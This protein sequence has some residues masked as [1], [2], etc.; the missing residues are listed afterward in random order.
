MY[1]AK[2]KNQIRKG[3]I[4]SSISNCKAFWT[5]QNYGDSR[6]QCLPGYYQEQ[7]GSGQER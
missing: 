3:Y 5:L 7:W 4:L 1:I 2:L 6:D